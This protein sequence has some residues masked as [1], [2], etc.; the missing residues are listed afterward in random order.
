MLKMKL[1]RLKRK[2]HVQPSQDNRAYMVKKLEKRS[3]VTCTKL[4][5]INL[6]TSYQKV[7]KTKIKIKAYVKCFECSILET[8]YPNVAT[9]KMIKQSLELISEK[10]LWL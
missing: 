6:K 5:Q 8:S 3:N 7:D 1:S 2:V 4:P 10:V 9:R